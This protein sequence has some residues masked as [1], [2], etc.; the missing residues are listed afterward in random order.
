MLEIAIRIVAESAT[1][2]IVLI[3]SLL[4]RGRG[5]ADFMI[6]H[7]TGTAHYRHG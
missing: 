3:M 6:P 1:S 2:R 7:E 5:M 4:F